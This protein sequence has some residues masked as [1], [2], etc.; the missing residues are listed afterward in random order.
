VAELDR[1]VGGR[2]LRLR[3]ATRHASLLGSTARSRLAALLGPGPAGGVSDTSAAVFGREVDITAAV[4]PRDESSLRE[5]LREASRLLASRG[6]TSVDEVTGS[7]DAVRVA[8]LAAAVAEGDVAQRVRVFV[9]DAEAAPSAA[10]AAGGHVEIVGVKLFAHDDAEAASPRFAAAVARARR[11]GWPVAVHAVEPDVVARVVEVLR[12]APPRAEV[13]GR[14]PRAALDRVEHASL[15]PPELAQVLARA[16]IAVVTQPG[17]L[18]ARGAK[19]LRD[20]EAPLR[21]WLYPLRTLL[22][23]G[24]VV[25]GG[26]DAPIGPLDP[27]I[28]LGA[29]IDRRAADGETIAPGEGVSPAVALDLYAGGPR[30][31][32]G[33]VP[34]G[35]RLLHEGWFVA[36]A[37]G[38]VVALARERAAAMTGRTPSAGPGDSNRKT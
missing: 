6:V 36:G 17:F 29:A 37:T 12:A 2:P 38:D 19:Y 1:A 16:G 7:N 9:N 24:V 13:D 21:E 33:E 28:A 32:R 11:A 34:R 5:G 4:G 31:V 15:C 14:P 27:A 3:H 23:A 8:R 35:A 30:R 26:S 25:A 22:A 18:R 20:V 10:R